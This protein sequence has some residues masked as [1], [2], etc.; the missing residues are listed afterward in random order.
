M[1]LCVNHT[2][3]NSDTTVSSGVCKH[4]RVYIKVIIE[5]PWTPCTIALTVATEQLAWHMPAVSQMTLTA[6]TAGCAVTIC[7]G[8]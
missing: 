6:V 7:T 2:Y 1:L 8:G 3:V 4:I 5:L